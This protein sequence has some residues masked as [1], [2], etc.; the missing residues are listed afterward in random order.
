LDP[1]MDCVSSP[2]AI[3]RVPIGKHTAR[4]RQRF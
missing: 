1:T 3:F 4:H 2:G